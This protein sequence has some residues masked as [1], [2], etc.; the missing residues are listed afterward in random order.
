MTRSGRT[1]FAALLALASLTARA[2]QKP[3]EAQQRP[4][5][6]GGTHF[7]RVDAYPSRDGRIVEG[8]RPDDF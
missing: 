5:F 2:Q 4:V 7:V 6:R 1:I 8:L 3:T